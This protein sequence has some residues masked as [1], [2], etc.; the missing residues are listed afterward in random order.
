MKHAAPLLFVG[1]TL[2]FAYEF[3]ATSAPY[4]HVYTEQ[5]ERHERSAPPALGCKIVPNMLMNE[6]ADEEEIIISDDEGTVQSG[7]CPGRSIEEASMGQ[8]ES[9]ENVALPG[10]IPT[11]TH[12]VLR[13]TPQ[14]LVLTIKAPDPTGEMVRASCAEQPAVSEYFGQPSKRA[15]KG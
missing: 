13:S 7:T 3:Q 4:T 12:F 8:G 5:S 1:T 14:T 15:K 2:E 9:S 11:K 10:S 6:K